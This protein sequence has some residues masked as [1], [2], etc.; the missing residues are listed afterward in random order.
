M[1]SG[2]GAKAGVAVNVDSPFRFQVLSLF[3]GIGGLD[4]SVRLALPGA[5]TIL[6]VERELAAATQLVALMHAGWLDPAPVFTD[7]VTLARRAG[8]SKLVREWEG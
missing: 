7:L 3:S 5:R 6:Y 8:L 1:G 2:D 4:V